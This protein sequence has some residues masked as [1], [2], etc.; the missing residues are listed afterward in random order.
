M[1]LRNYQKE[2]IEAVISKPS[3]KYLVCLTTGLG[4]SLTASQIPRSGRILWLARQR[5]LV[6]QPQS[7]FD[8][9]IGVEMGNQTSNGEEAIFATVQSISRRLDK[10]KPND[11]ELVV[12]DECFEPDAEI[13][14]N[15]GFVKFCELGDEKVAQIDDDRNISFVTPTRR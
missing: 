13:L 2:A 5:E 14:T 9:S 10:F 1:E 8:C 4:K 12:G 6:T 3:G 11:F 15:K 7:Y